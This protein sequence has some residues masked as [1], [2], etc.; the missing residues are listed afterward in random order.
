MRA[1]LPRVAQVLLLPV[2]VLVAIAS[3]ISGPNATA[4]S[5][6]PAAPAAAPA[7]TAF[8]VPGDCQPHGHSRGGRGLHR[9]IGA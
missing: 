8:T 9:D 6:A 1:P 4:A 2:L 7:S 3:L 5:P